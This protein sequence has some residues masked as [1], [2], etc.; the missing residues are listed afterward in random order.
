MLSVT[1]IISDIRHNSWKSQK[2]PTIYDIYR[3]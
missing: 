2:L 1:P 3:R